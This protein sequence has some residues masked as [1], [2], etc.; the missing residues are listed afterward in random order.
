[1]DNLDGIGRGGAGRA[2]GCGFERGRGEALEV[3]GIGGGAGRVER[4]KEVIGLNPKVVEVVEL[5]VF[6][7]FSFEPCRSCFCSACSACSA[8]SSCSSCVARMRFPV[9]G[10]RGRGKGAV[11]FEV[12]GLEVRFG[13]LRAVVDC[14]IEGGG[15][16]NA[17]IAIR[18]EGGIR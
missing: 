5:L 13:A 7:F 16:T 12:D 14:G 11:S 6:C 15:G 10:G 18:M 17:F 2:S 1:M 9:R 4:L 8:H 3:G